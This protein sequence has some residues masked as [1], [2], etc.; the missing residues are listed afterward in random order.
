VN[1]LVIVQNNSRYT[2]Q[3][4]KYFYV[5]D[6]TYNLI[7]DVRPAE[8]QLSK[9]GL[10]DNFLGAFPLIDVYLHVILDPMRTTCVPDMKSGCIMRA[11][12]RIAL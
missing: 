3:V 6:I 2:V 10:S 7:Q 5:S 1:L 9:H 4:L 8:L 11:I 12:P